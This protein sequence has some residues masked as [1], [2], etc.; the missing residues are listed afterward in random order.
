MRS[1]SG[2]PWHRP[3]GRRTGGRPLQLAPGAGR[4]AGRPVRAAL[5]GRAAPRRP[6]RH[7]A[8]ARAWPRPLPRA[9]RRPRSDARGPRPG[10]ASGQCR[11]LSAGSSVAVTH[12]R[13]P[14]RPG[15]RPHGLDSRASRTSPSLSRHHPRPSGRRPELRSTRP[16]AGRPG[17]LRTCSPGCEQRLALAHLGVDPLGRGHLG[18]LRQLADDRH[19][20]SPLMPG[21]QPSTSPKRGQASPSLPQVLPCARLCPKNRDETRK[22]QGIRDPLVLPQATLPQRVEPGSSA[23]LSVT[24]RALGQEQAPGRPAPARRARRE[25][26]QVGCAD[27]AAHVALAAAA[28]ALGQ[29]GDNTLDWS[30]LCDERSVMVQPRR[31]IGASPEGPQGQEKRPCSGGRAG[32]E[33]TSRAR[34][35]RSAY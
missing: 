19:V 30:G 21:P 8:S 22:S 27:P 17:R 13:R 29:L 7:R 24:R 12:R 11:A 6:Q 16:A 26:D 18:C 9:V 14:S 10:P 32:Q 35:G 1:A 25:R 4:P 23:A 5:H 20:V 2:Q 34:I 3:Q 15:A 31:M 33:G 28:G